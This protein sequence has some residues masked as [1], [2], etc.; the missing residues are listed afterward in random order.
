MR[1]DRVL[2]LKILRWFETRDQETPLSTIS[3]GEYPERIITDHIRMMIEENLLSGKVMY[4]SGQKQP[5]LSVDR[6][7][8]EGYDLLSVLEK[9][10]KVPELSA[11]HRS[12]DLTIK[13]YDSLNQALKK[14]TEIAKVFDLSHTTAEVLKKSMTDTGS[15]RDGRY[16]GR[17]ISDFLVGR[18]GILPNIMPLSQGRGPLSPIGTLSEVIRSLPKGDESAVPGPGLSRDDK[19]RIERQLDEIVIADKDSSFNVAGYELLYTL[20]RMLRDVIHQRIMV[21]NAKDL[22]SKIPNDV[23]EGMTGRKRAEEQCNVAEGEYELIE[24]CDFTDLKRILEKGRNRNLFR[25][26]F[27]EDEIKT[28]FAKLAELDPIRKKIAHS[29]PLTRREFERLK[30]Y[31]S[32]ILARISPE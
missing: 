20:E 29:R 21:P 32:D 2:I 1:R 12:Q 28:V 25:D 13:Y 26:I 14:V 24:Y 8:S 22:A 10:I 11:P 16:P 23:L 15:E 5:V 27:S 17:V 9:E 4:V 7:T 30:L 3:I 19:E 31:A 6:I 18:A